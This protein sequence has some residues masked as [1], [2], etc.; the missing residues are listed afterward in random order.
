[1]SDYALSEK[2]VVSERTNCQKDFLF[3]KLSHFPRNQNP[4]FHIQ[5]EVDMLHVKIIKQV[6]N[7]QMH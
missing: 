1:M 3:V 7:A 4:K 6:P 2:Q 5:R